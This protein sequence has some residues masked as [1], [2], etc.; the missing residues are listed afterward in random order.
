[1][2][3][4]R[5]I[6]GTTSTHL[7]LHEAYDLFTNRDGDSGAREGVPKLAIVLTDGHSQ[8]SPRNLAQRLKSEGVE[9]LAVS[10]TPRPYVDERELLG[11]TEDASK[12]FTPSNVQVLMRPD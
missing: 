9:I 2:N 4:L 11:I 7:A 10:M 5:S 1:L 3:T 12:V 8:R 6:K